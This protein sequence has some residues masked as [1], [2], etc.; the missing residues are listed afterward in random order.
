[1][2]KGTT[3]WNGFEIKCSIPGAAQVLCLLFLEILVSGDLGGKETS[4]CAFE[5]RIGYDGSDTVV[6]EG[7]SEGLRIVLSMRDSMAKAIISNPII[8]AVAR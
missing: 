4:S 8:T 2:K 5:E 6:S 3:C 1:M 7:V